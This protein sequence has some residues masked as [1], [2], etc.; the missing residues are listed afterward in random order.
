MVLSRL[1][2]YLEGFENFGILIG[3]LRSQENLNS[4]DVQNNL[5]FLNLVRREIAAF[6]RDNENTFD[7]L[8]SYFNRYLNRFTER[9]EFNL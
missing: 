5:D 9:L 1:S 3:I 7:R 4:E 6:Q 2:C 8:E